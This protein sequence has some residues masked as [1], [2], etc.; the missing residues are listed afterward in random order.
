MCNTAILCYNLSFMN[1]LFLFQVRGFFG[2][3]RFHLKR[4]VH[5][6]DGVIF[7]NSGAR[8]IVGD[9]AIFSNNVV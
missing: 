2:K 8:S 6:N 3:F 5:M 9:G 7:G 1:G 4:E